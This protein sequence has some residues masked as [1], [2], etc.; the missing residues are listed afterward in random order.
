[1]NNPLLITFHDIR[2]STKVEDLIKEKFAKLQAERAD[3]TKC[4]VFIEKETKH[5][6]SSSAVVVRLD[7]KMPHIEDIVISEKA[8]EDESTL[9][10]A[11]IKAFKKSHE[12]FHERMKYLRDQKRAA[13]ARGVM[14]EEDV[15]EPV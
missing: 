8:T 12:L 10:A 7:L 5:H 9:T 2:H 4:H 11:V 13:S 6:R 3:V 1:M 14:V 15:S